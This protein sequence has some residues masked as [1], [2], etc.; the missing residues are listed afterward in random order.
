MD[1]WFINLCVISK[2]CLMIFPLSG[3]AIA[4][5]GVF[6]CLIGGAISE[7]IGKK[8][9]VFLSNLVV[10][11]LWIAL[12]FAR[13]SWMIILLRFSIGLFSSSAYSCVGKIH[14]KCGYEEYKTNASS[15]VVISETSHP[16]LR[17]V[18][19]PLQA[20]GAMLGFLFANIT[21]L[22]EA[23]RSSALIL[24]FVPLVA[25]GSMYLF[26]ETPYWLAKMGRIDDAKYLSQILFL[27]T[28]QTFPSFL[29]NPWNFIEAKMLLGFT[30]SYHPSSTV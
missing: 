16:K 7:R 27:A 12:S 24:A 17:K 18:L 10:M 30:W 29:E 28:R 13:I 20:I 23:W 6:G 3:A 4:L 5:G 25:S 2:Y 26:P 9:V 14:I 11:A 8:L 22:L 1:W 21:G 15:G 19:G